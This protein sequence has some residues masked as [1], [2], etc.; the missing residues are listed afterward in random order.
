MDHMRVGDVV[1]GH[2]PFEIGN[3]ASGGD[4]SI[5]FCGQRLDELILDSLSTS[6]DF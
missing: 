1:V 4:D 3:I 6:N 5:A 2:L